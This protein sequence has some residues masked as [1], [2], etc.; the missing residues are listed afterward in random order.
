MLLK[1]CIFNVSDAPQ[2]AQTCIFISPEAL[3]EAQTCIFNGPEAPQE[4]ETC[5][6]NG[7]GGVVS[8]RISERY[9]TIFDNI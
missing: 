7:W 1:S 8:K 4:A 2:E 5:I 6:F 9:L 3:K